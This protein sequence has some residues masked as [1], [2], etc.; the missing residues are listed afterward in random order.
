[1][2][3]VVGAMGGRAAEE[4]VYGTRTT[5]AENDMQQATDLVRSMVTLWGMSEKLGPVALAA[6]ESPFLGDVTIPGNRPYSETTATLVDGEVQRIVQQSY[7]T[8]LTMLS[9]HRSEL[10][11]LAGALLEHETIEAAELAEV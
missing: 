11:L 7:D 4:L 1:M 5:G 6:R 9:E 3:R 2:S 8:A 10:D